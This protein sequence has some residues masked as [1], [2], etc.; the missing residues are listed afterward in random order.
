MNYNK[1]FSQHGFKRYKGSYY[2]YVGNGV[3]QQIRTDEKERLSRDAPTYSKAHRFD[4]IVVIYLY[5]LY[6]DESTSSF[7]EKGLPS[8]LRLYTDEL[9]GIHCNSIFFDGIE[10]DINKMEEKGFSIL[11]SIDTRQAMIDAYEPFAVGDSKL[12]KM[13]SPYL[14][15]GYIE[16]ARAALDGLFCW[17]VD[18][19]MSK[20][21]QL[22]SESENLYKQLCEKAEW[23]Y[24]LRRLT[25]PVNEHEASAYL[26]ANFRRN[27][28]L[29][30]EMGLVNE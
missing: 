5:S 30:V 17:N 20:R 15:C 6:S 23:F 21:L 27:Y 13:F 2:K 25:Y 3:L 4:N 9:L 24:R 8:P 22:P 26:D 18:A 28:S 7:F 10:S 11:E 12:L 16:K 14:Y 29:I 1:L 19:I